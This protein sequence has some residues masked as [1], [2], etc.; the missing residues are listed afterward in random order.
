[1]HYGIW[2]EAWESCCRVHCID[3]TERERERISIA[4]KD[5]YYATQSVDQSENTETDE[6]A[7][8]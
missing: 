6:A 2:N 5:S 4:V 1:M 3:M 8:S 7:T